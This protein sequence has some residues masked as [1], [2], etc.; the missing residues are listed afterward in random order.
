MVSY[1]SLYFAFRNLPA[2]RY[3]SHFSLQLGDGLFGPV[4]INGPTTANY[5]EDLGPFN[6]QDWGHESVFTVWEQS[7][8]VLAIDQPELANGL[9]RGTNTFD[10]TGQPDPPCLGTGQRTETNFESGQKYLMRIIGSQIDGYMKFTI[11]GHGFTV[12]ASDFVPIE[13]YYTNSVI[14]SSGQRY[15]IIVEANQPV[16][17]YWMRAI[18]QTACNQNNNENK[19]NILGIVRYTGANTTGDPTTTVWSNIT[20]SCGDED[21]S[22]LTPWLNLNVGSSVAETWLPVQW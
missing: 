5:D 19:D 11:D 6:I 13:P 21:Y 9:I 1:P 22:N 2:V 4:V 18:Y 12:I 14:L 8:R 15:D 20:D 3:H 7:Q 10:C 17:N 16:D